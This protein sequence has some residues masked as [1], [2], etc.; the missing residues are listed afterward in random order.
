MNEGEFFK[1]GGTA[2]NII[3]IVACLAFIPLDIRDHR[4]FGLGLDLV[5][6]LGLVYVEIQKWRRDNV[7]T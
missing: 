1:I 3:I 2:F 4:W 7:K 5:F 6:G